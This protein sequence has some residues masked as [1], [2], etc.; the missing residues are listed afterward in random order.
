M[1][2][3]MALHLGRWTTTETGSPYNLAEIWP[4]MR[5]AMEYMDNTR[6]QIFEGNLKLAMFSSILAREQGPKR[7]RRKP[8]AAP[9]C[10]WPVPGIDVSSFGADNI[11]Q[12]VKG[13]SD[14]LHARRQ[15]G[16]EDALGVNALAMLDVQ[17]AL[18]FRQR[19]YAEDAARHHER[20]LHTLHSGLEQFP[21]SFALRWNQAHWALFYSG[22]TASSDKAF[23]RIIADFENLTFEPIGADICFGLGTRN[24]DPIFWEYEYGNLALLTCT[25][26]ADP[27]S[28]RDFLIATATGYRG[29]IA[30][31]EGRPCEGRMHYQRALDCWPDHVPILLR[32][33]SN[34]LSAIER[35][36]AVNP[37]HS[38]S[39]DLRQLLSRGQVIYPRLLLDSIREV[40]RNS[41]R[42]FIGEDLTVLL[43]S[44]FRL[45]RVVRSSRT[46]SHFPCN[47][48]D[49]ELLASVKPFW[50]MALAEAVEQSP[51][52]SRGHCRAD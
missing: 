2:E 24:W 33:V 50:P 48:A 8:D 26:G 13:L 28:L 20:A 29:F 32:I 21:S 22:E 5:S 52:G 31:L 19:E 45:R 27:G 36:Q 39:H 12:R 3:D 47:E 40:L 10:I 4:A 37:N 49:L 7:S 17:L 30:E 46:V 34:I 6:E 35:D 38:L 1:L 9:P 16:R 42:I 51:T 25:S 44:W 41:S 43:E 11:L 18:M 23:S 15:S 14:R